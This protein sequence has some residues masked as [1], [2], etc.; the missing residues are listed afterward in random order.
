M[1]FSTI[2]LN[3]S[4]IYLEE[5]FHPEAAVSLDFHALEGTECYCDKP[6]EAFIREAL[7]PW[8]AE[9]LHWIDGGDYH[10]A[11]L[12]WIEKIREPFDL[13]LLDHH[14][15]DQEPAFGDGILSCGGWVA[16]ARR[17]LPLLQDTVWI[18]E[19]PADVSS[20]LPVYLS[21]DKDVLS[22]EFARTN[23]DQGSQTLAGLKEILR[24]I[25]ARRRILGIDVCGGL[26]LSKGAC[27][28][29]VEINRR[30]DEELQAFLV[31]LQTV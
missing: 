31:S 28:K 14:S 12:F 2:L 17:Q 30:T 13:F 23:W 8:P 19:G 10:Y 21:I 11:S 18:Q 22:P 27:G 1:A 7:R 15:D 29:D 26:S 25:A 6:A 16:T 24:T 4:G 3:F 5:E 9:A 20:G